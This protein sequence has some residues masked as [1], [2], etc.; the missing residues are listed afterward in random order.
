MDADGQVIDEP[1]LHRLSYTVNIEGDDLGL[2]E[3]L[4]DLVRTISD[5]WNK[6]LE[7]KNRGLLLQMIAPAART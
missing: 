4:I 7:Y 2:M 5:C 3:R 1:V 6:I